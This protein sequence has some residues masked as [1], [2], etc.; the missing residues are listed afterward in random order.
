MPIFLS[1]GFRHGRDVLLDHVPDGA[2][3]GQRHQFCTPILDEKTLNCTFHSDHSGS[4]RLGFAVGLI[5]FE[6]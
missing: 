3:D 4:V 2:R 5:A 6:K 1:P